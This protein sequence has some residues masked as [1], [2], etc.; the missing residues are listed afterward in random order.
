MAFVTPTRIVVAETIPVVSVVPTTVTWSF[1]LR[2]ESFTSVSVVLT[3]RVLVAR[4]GQRRNDAD[5][6]L[7]CFQFQTPLS[8][9]IR[10]EVPG[11]DGAAPRAP[12]GRDRRRL[13][14]RPK[15]RPR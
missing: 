14:S 1:T 4:E 9:A 7:W 8:I 15:R 13:R 6:D 5:H 10:I 12:R 3:I 11:S 2:S